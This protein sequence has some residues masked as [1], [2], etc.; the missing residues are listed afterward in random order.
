MSE[1]A[2]GAESKGSAQRSLLDELLAELSKAGGSVSSTEISDVI[3]KLQST[4]DS[5]KKREDRERARKKKE[6]AA[7]KAEEDRIRN[8]NHIKSVTSMDLPTDW[9]NL[10]AGDHRAEG[11]HADSIPDGLI[12]SLTNLGRVDIEYISTITGADLKSIILTLK[13]SIY[14][15]PE[16][17][18]ECFY[19]GWET[20]EEYLSG[21]MVQKWKSAKAANEKYQ[22]YFSENVAAIEKVLPPTVSSEDIYITLGSPWVPE[23]IIDE[24]IRHILKLPNTPRYTTHDPYTGSWEIFNKSAY[25]DQVAAKSTYGTPRMTALYI[26]ERTLNMKTIYIT[27]EVTCCTS[28]SG[29]KRF[30]NQAETVAA[31]EKQ[32]KMIAE[33]QKWVW[34]DPSRKAKLEMIFEN[35]FGCIRKRHFDGSFLTFPNMSPAVQ[36]YPYQKDA[37]ARILFSPNTLLAHDVGSGKTYVMIA[38]GMELRR[39]G[40]SKKNL[41]VVPN[42]LVGQWRDIFLT[43]Y[44]DANILCIEP[45]G[46]SPAKRERVLEAI[47]DKDYDGI[48]MAYSCFEG[49][50][51]SQAHYIKELEET[52]DMVKKLLETSKGGTGKLRRKAKSVDEALFKAITEVLKTDC[53][54]FFDEL[55]ITRLFVDE[56]H[57]FKNVP[58][59]TQVGHV[60]GISPDGSK[61]CQDMMDKVHLIQKNNS[62][63]GVVMATGTPITN[64]VTDAYIMQKYLQSG[65][66]AMLDLQNFDSWI[67]MFAEKVTEFEIDVDTSSYRLATRFAK[68]HNL[69]ELTTLL[70]S[71][72]DFHQVEVSD[73]IPETD[74]YSD[75]LIGKTREFSDYLRNIS[76]RADDVRHGR[77]NRADD[78]ML[79]ITTDGRKA[80]LDLR[81]VD[82][83]SRFTYQSKIARCAENVWNIYRKTTAQKST[84]LIFCDSSTPKKGFN[85]YDEL[86][87]LLFSM[88]IPAE[89]IAFIHDA[90]TDKKRKTL[91]RQV[92]TGQVRVLIG[93]TFKLGLGVNVQD[94]LIAIHHLDVPWR[95]ADMTQREGRIL[96]QGN[97][98][99]R[100]KIF[101]YIT[102]G[103][104]DAYSWQLLEIKQRFIA[105]LLSGS[106]ADRSGS[107]IEDTVLDYAEV[108]ALAV[109]NPLVKQRVET[110]NEL[111]RLLTL[112]RKAVE[113]R[114]TL[115]KELSELPGRMTRQESLIQKC[116][117]DADF[118]LQTF[119]I[120]D[121]EIRRQIRKDIYDAV[122]IN[123]LATKE[124]ILMIYQGFEIILPTNMRKE[125]PYV[126]LQRQG[127][128]YVELGDSEVGCLIRV[129]N[130]LE[131]LPAYLEKLQNHLLD[132]QQRETELQAELQKKEDFTE[133]ITE[134]KDALAKLDKKLG[135]TKS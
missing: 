97:E 28:K 110:A 41:Y 61:K 58:I 112:Q 64:S 13:G 51:L 72:A 82:P 42:N 135:V 53:N 89:E 100:V 38:A 133:K 80:A 120:Q 124:T 117:D 131:G 23:E 93:S 20:T 6:E 96:R 12:L 87:A 50:A 27:D 86:H 134:C 121:K 8:E 129:D 81:L 78:N 22:G 25:N 99:K 5:V 35:Q 60:L 79:K 24:Y 107:D 52:R 127:R 116:Q 85:I 70:S 4:R 123:E 11:V 75:A 37:V 67:G 109:G 46:F 66:L 29:K 104:F 47:R 57:N 91:F 18:N 30:I 49:I 63:G 45:K 101:R 16:T 68:F 111:S 77:V 3:R 128:Y 7:K 113:N 17:W 44:P 108:K 95:P 59:E 83:K 10:F 19:K 105:G 32:K 98:N 88:G 92:Q 126:W 114:I 54:V 9:E 43:L 33:F 65:E 26:L 39:M 62:G 125:K 34:K 115:E 2:T 31:L 130:A 76:S 106:L 118:M 102:E 40:L 15:N 90:D 48:I 94:K 103:S 21:N 73:G 84:Q 132:M 56:A 71:I 1:K 36:L 74:G 122:C 119:T 55:G 69:P 14:Q